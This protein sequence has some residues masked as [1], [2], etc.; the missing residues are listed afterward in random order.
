[1]DRN[2]CHRL[3]AADAMTKVLVLHFLALHALFDVKSG[4]GS[5]VCSCRVRIG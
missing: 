4:K 1:M 3:P 5:K 2:C